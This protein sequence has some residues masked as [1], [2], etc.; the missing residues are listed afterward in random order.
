MVVRWAFASHGMMLSLADEIAA[1]AWPRD[2][3]RK[4]LATIEAYFDE[5]GIH[6]RARICAAGGYFG[7]PGQMKRLE[8]AWKRTLAIY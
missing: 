4:I 3:H 2:G 7:G 1:P 6:D 8:C 5:S